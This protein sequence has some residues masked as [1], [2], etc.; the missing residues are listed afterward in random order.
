MD[1]YV[2]FSR[3]LGETVSSIYSLLRTVVGAQ[4]H[5]GKD[6]VGFEP[7]VFFVN[8]IVFK[9][10]ALNRSTTYPLFYGDS[11]AKRNLDGIS[12]VNTVLYL[13]FQRTGSFRAF[14]RNKFFLWFF[15][16]VDMLTSRAGRFANSGYWFSNS[17]NISLFPGI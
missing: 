7:T 14:A 6:K 8:T 17:F 3:K 13:T 16:S 10:N 2:F 1:S 15:E 11:F 9:T 5:I 12:S 4:S